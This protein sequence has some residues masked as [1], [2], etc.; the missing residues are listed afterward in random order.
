MA[1]PVWCAICAVYLWLHFR[2]PNEGALENI[3]TAFDF[4]SIK[5]KI[6]MFHVPSWFLQ[7]AAICDPCIRLLKAGE[8][9]KVVYVIF[10]YQQSWQVI[11]LERK[12]FFRVDKPYGGTAGKPAVLF[13]IPDGRVV[14]TAATAAGKNWY[15][16]SLCIA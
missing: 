5:K 2:T 6:I 9:M 1:E 11:Q 4:I 8:V 16:K 13:A 10:S 14:K 3:V 7:S 15:W 12:G